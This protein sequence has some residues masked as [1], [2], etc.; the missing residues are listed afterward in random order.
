VTDEWFKARWSGVLREDKK[1]DLSLPILPRLLDFFQCLCQIVALVLFRL[2]NDLGSSNSALDSERDNV[3]AHY[4]VMR[5]RRSYCRSP[6]KRRLPCASQPEALRLL[7]LG[8]RRR[9]E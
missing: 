2:D 7:L 5:S 1:T 3:I 4:A 6:R 8:I 9:A